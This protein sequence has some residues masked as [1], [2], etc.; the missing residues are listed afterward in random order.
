MIPIF[1]QA[2]V[3]ELRAELQTVLS[4]WPNWMLVDYQSILYFSFGT[5]TRYFCSL[6]LRD[7][8]EVFWRNG[9]N[10]RI[11]HRIGNI[12]QTQL[13]EDGATAIVN[14][15]RADVLPFLNT[16]L[17]TESIAA[18]L[19]VWKAHQLCGQ[20]AKVNDI[21]WYRE[22]IEQAERN[23][24]ASSSRSEDEV[25]RWRLFLMTVQSFLRYPS[26]WDVCFFQHNW[27]SIAGDTDWHSAVS[28]YKELLWKPSPQPASNEFNHYVWFRE[29]ADLETLLMADHVI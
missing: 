3:A 29:K 1:R 2:I 5:E 18:D 23:L 9:V 28:R 10:S 27:N 14:G 19:I 26:G 6:V 22:L 16:A 8:G 7:D 20:I 15:I 12:D 21:A 25:C 17:E 11:E 24:L 4:E 13:F